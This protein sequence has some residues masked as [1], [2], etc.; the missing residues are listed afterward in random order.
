MVVFSIQRSEAFPI[1]MNAHIHG[2][3]ICRGNLSRE[4]AEHRQGQ[5]QNLN[6]K[7]TIEPE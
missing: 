3:A 6:L 5:L 2:S 1:T 7:A 4:L